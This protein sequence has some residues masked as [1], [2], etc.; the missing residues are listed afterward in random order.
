MTTRRTVPADRTAAIAALGDPRVIDQEHVRAWTDGNGGF[1]TLDVARRPLPDMGAIVGAR[2]RRQ[3]YELALAACQGALDFGATHATF[4]VIQ[5]TMLTDIE[6][7]FD[8]APVV[9]AAVDDEPVGWTITVDLEDAKQQLL[10]WL[11]RT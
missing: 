8:V 6:R 9:I 5:R 3:R 7:S 11:S 2:G 4:D 10:S 1:V